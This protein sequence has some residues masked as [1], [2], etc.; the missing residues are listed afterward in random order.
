MTVRINHRSVEYT[1]TM[2]SPDTIHESAKREPVTHTVET[3]IIEQGG[4]VIEVTTR[5]YSD[6][7]VKKTTAICKKGY[8]EVL[9]K[10][11]NSME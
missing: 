1:T 7:V 8:H 10:K 2:E 11:I 3:Q 9:Q 6:G 4:K 5:T